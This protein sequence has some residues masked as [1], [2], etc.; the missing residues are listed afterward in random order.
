M[1]LMHF[2]RSLICPDVAQ[3]Q[4]EYAELFKNYTALEYRANSLAKAITNN[5]IVPPASEFTLDEKEYHP[6]QDSHLMSYIS[7]IAD[8]TYYSFP[9]YQWRNLLTPIQKILK[10]TLNYESNISDCDDFA[11]IMNS[12]IAISFIKGNYDYQGAFLTLWSDRHAYN[13]YVDEDKNVWVYEPQTNRTIGKLGETDGNYAT[14]KVWIPGVK[15][16]Q[17]P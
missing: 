2:L 10:E 3:L 15:S 17:A 8:A 7:S 9:K 5:M 14:K 13:G 12:Y 1:S 11:L 4:L 6:F 16:S